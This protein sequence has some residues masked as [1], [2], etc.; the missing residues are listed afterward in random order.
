[1]YCTLP[2]CAPQTHPFPMSFITTY[3]F[4]N[5]YHWLKVSVGRKYYGPLYFMCGLKNE[6]ASNYINIEI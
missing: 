5:S 6:V 1:M 3:T 4:Y 2:L